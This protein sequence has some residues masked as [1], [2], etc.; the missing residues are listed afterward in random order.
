MITIPLTQDQVAVI[1]TAD[2]A[3]IQQYTWR[4]E[5]RRDTWYATTRIRSTKAKSGWS[6]T[7]MHRLLLP[8]PDRML[9][10]DHINGDGLDNR[11]RN[12]RLVT[13]AQNHWNSHNSYAAS[14]KYKGVYWHTLRGQWHAKLMHKGKTI[15]AG[16]H[17]SEQTA[18]LAY[19]AAAAHWFGEYACLNRVA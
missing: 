14:S 13:H 4:A 7:Y 3:L 10:V 15:C 5:K 16:F 2:A 1:D 12:L 8:P 19:N 17:G 18:A 11:R 6:T 9:V